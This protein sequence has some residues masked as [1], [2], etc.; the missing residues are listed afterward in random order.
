MRKLF[1]T[2]LVV[3]SAAPCFAGD[4]FKIVENICANDVRVGH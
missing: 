2:L 1:I 4:D 3:L